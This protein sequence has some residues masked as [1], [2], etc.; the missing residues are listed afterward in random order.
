MRI[1]RLRSYAMADG[2]RSF[3]NVTFNS[4]GPP[5]RGAAGVCVP[6]VAST[7]AA[8]FT[9]GYSRALLRSGRPA[10]KKVLP[11]NRQHLSK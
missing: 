4:A 11:G 5:G 10:K 2:P 6:R 8:D 3:E 9:L 7:L 1:L